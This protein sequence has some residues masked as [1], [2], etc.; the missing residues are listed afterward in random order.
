MAVAASMV[1][2]ASPTADLALWAVE[3]MPGGAVTVQEGALEIRDKAG[4]TVWWREKLTAP[5]EIRF[6]VTPIL[7]AAPT[8]RISDINCFW[9]AR[10]SQSPD[11][12]PYAPGH[13]RSGKFMEYNSL[14]TYYV[15]YGAN[16]NTTTRFRRYNGTAERPLLPEHDLSDRRFM[17]TANRPVHIRVVAREGV[18][19]YWRD[20][21]L[22][23]RYRD[24]QPLTSGWFAFRTVRSHLRITDF[25]VIPGADAQTAARPGE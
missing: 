21:E 25:A 5:V 22:V 2:G 12:V 18:A 16:N 1:R 14:L 17:L 11:A 9:M 23:F 4:C 15:G 7:G 20:G 10:E 13:A 24:P 6:T 19:E 3:Q 8:D